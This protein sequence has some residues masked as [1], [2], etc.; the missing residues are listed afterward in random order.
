[1]QYHL[2]RHLSDNTDEMARDNSLKDF[3]RNASNT[4]IGKFYKIEKTFKMAQDVAKVSKKRLED[5]VLKHNDLMDQYRKLDTF[6]FI[7][8]RDRDKTVNGQKMNQINAEMN[9][10]AQANQIDLKQIEKEKKTI[11]KGSLSS[12]IATVG[13]T[14]KPEIN[15]KAINEIC[16]DVLLN[17]KTVLTESQQRTVTDIANQC[18]KVGGDAVFKARTLYQMIE[19]KL[20]ID[21]DKNCEQ[22]A[23][24]VNNDI[25]TIKA[26]IPTKYFGVYPNP[27][28]DFIQLEAENLS[29]NGEWL[30]INA[31]GKVAVRYQ[32]TKVTAD[33]RD[34]PTG[35]YFVSYRSEG[36]ER[37]NS[38]FVKTN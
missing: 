11:L 13:V 27:T 25:E 17:D 1:M 26:N 16:L 38:K 35:V 3:Y 19:S 15:E 24:L 8:K 5:N 37:F 23:S 12:D 2:Y 20:F 10:I 21:D 6:S 33:I 28:K 14:L 32:Q 29:E 18:P 7:S 36:V 4:S 9:K 22:V 30:I 34:L 31:M